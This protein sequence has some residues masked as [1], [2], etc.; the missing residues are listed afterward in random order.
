MDSLANS[1][2]NP[3]NNPSLDLQTFNKGFHDA[4][5]VLYPPYFSSQ[6]LSETILSLIKA[7]SEQEEPRLDLSFQASVALH[8]LFRPQLHSQVH[9]VNLLEAWDQ[10]YSSQYIEENKTFDP[11]EYFLKDQKAQDLLDMTLEA[12]KEALKGLVKFIQDI[13]NMLNQVKKSTTLKHKGQICQ[14]L[15][16][17]QAFYSGYQGQ[18]SALISNINQKRMILH[19]PYDQDLEKLCDLLKPKALI[20]GDIFPEGTTVFRIPQDLCQRI[21]TEKNIFKPSNPSIF[22][23]I[24]QN[25]MIY[26]FYRLL[27]IPIPHKTPIILAEDNG[28][29]HFFEVSEALPDSIPLP[30]NS[31]EWPENHHKTFC[32]Q[33]LGTILTTPSNPHFVYDPIKYGP[34][35]EN[36]LDSSYFNPALSPSVDNSYTINSGS[37]LYS[38]PAMDHPLPDSLRISLRTLSIDLF[39]LTWLKDLETKRQTRQQLISTCLL[40]SQDL[41]QPKHTIPQALIDSLRTKL[42]LM[43]KACNT[44]H[45]EITPQN[46]LETVF[47]T[48]GA[49]YKALRSLNPQSNLQNPSTL[50]LAN[51]NSSP[52]I[53]LQDAFQS[54][55]KAY[56]KTYPHILDIFM[57]KYSEQRMN[58]QEFMKKFSECQ[59][60]QQLFNQKYPECRLMKQ[61]DPQEALRELI[62]Y[63]EFN[64][65]HVQ[66]ARNFVDLWCKGRNVISTDYR[67]LWDLLFFS[68]DNLEVQW[69]LALD[70]YLPR[71]N[72]SGYHPENPSEVRGALIS[73][74]Q[75]SQEL[76]KDIFNQN[77]S[78]RPLPLVRFPRDQNQA[79]V[80]YIKKEPELAGYEY[81]VTLFLRAFGVEGIP[82][83]ELLIMKDP[84]QGLYSALL[85]QA[86]EGKT[87]EKTWLQ[88]DH[89]FE[90]LEPHHTQMLMLGSMLL[91]PED[92]RAS[93]FILTKNEKRIIP[94]HNGHVFVP[95]FV[96][97]SNK[98]KEL[99]NKTILF[100]L[101][102]MNKPIQESVIHKIINLDIDNLLNLWLDKLLLF[103][104]RSHHLPTD[105]VRRR[106][107]AKGIF[108]RLGFPEKFIENLYAKL[109]KMQEKLSTNDPQLRPFD[110]LFELEPEVGKAYHEVFFQESTVRNRFT[111]LTESLYKSSKDP[112]YNSL[113]LL[114]I[115]GITPQELAGE[116]FTPK[117]GPFEARKIV[118]NC[119]QASKKVFHYMN[120][121]KGRVQIEVEDAQKLQGETGE[122]FV[123]RKLEDQE[124]QILALKNSSIKDFSKVFVE[125]T[126]LKALVLPSTKNL[127]QGSL[128][129][130]G[131]SFPNLESLTIGD[132]NELKALALEQENF[133]NLKHLNVSNCPNLMYL[134]VEIPALEALE[135][136]C[137]KDLKI[138]GLVTM[139]LKY[140]D[141]QEEKMEILYVNKGVRKAEIIGK[142]VE[143]LEEKMGGLELFRTAGIVEKVL[144]SDIDEK[145]KQDILKL[146]FPE[147]V[148]KVLEKK[149]QKK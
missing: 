27:D 50:E 53:P 149:L 88:N 34:V 123:K 97:K 110:L 43:T 120:I 137:N 26:S 68:I 60:N 102:E 19:L 136:A 105:D 76:Q 129:I 87:L 140:L 30:D 17:L 147:G 59:M 78:L 32:L 62:L 45:T 12:K 115:L 67:N 44:S 130:F 36:T 80:F 52:A 8:S 112:Q 98:T 148:R 51:P 40:Y 93:N 69:F 100:C 83:C 96:S 20:F 128:K 16:G 103:N 118:A 35:L 79:P 126:S 74:R 24:E 117:I 86:I 75:L 104:D 133:L 142:S 116:H 106:D 37:P 95:G 22:Q 54:A 18:V 114:E 21:M 127:T 144:M 25:D 141:C 91:N 119:S 89:I 64:I 49:H 90:G 99:L 82:F 57:E 29:L 131:K 73:K 71:D 61:L 121:I 46:L 113:E 84:Q 38:H 41:P 65:H 108:Y 6:T 4:K 81:A 13:E 10:L 48:L 23:Q 92:G 1:F 122:D 125:R 11:P 42:D 66:N 56:F 28:N 39:L 72:S 138:V 7:E 145:G 135:I 77:Q 9:D 33:V 15:F 107:A 2:I 85:M 63:L 109:L 3:A 55:Y 47:P 94:I 14:A 58:R 111:K 134:R 143:E 146:M 31:L 101:P 124:L 70:K 139:E 5:Q 132:N